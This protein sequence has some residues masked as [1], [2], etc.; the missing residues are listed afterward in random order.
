MPV[1]DGKGLRPG[2]G[3]RSRSISSALFLP[4]PSEE[5]LI[6][7]ASASRGCWQVIFCFMASNMPAGALPSTVQTK[8]PEIPIA[9]L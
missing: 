1:E 6:Y 3:H 2:G 9:T 4:L 7:R 8:L 5:R